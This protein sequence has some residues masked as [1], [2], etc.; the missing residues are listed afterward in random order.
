ML[1]ATETMCQSFVV[2]DR[3]S[4]Q[5]RL[6]VDGTA[7]E[8]QLL[9]GSVGSLSI[10][11]GAN[12]TI[13]DISAVSH[14]SADS[15]EPLLLAADLTSGQNQFFKG[16]LDEVRIYIPD[17]TPLQIA[18]FADEDNDGTSDIWEMAL[19]GHLENSPSLGCDSKR[20]QRFK[21]REQ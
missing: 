6:Y 19:F 2:V 21:R 18:A 8:V 20:V 16:T 14:L 17:L 1:I 5:I 3:L 9:S 11:P 4:K 15:D 7:Q 13:V 10:A 12:G